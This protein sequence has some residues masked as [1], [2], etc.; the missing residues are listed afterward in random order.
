ME[1]GIDQTLMIDAAIIAMR[2]QMATDPNLAL[3]EEMSPGLI[4]ELAQS[5]RPAF[6]DHQMRTREIYIPRMAALFAKHLTPAEARA[7]AQFYR[8]DIGRRLLKLTSSNYS[9]D[10]MLAE[11]ME[12]NEITQEMVEKDVG[13]T[14]SNVVD[15]LTPEEMRELARASMD[16]PA[17]MK[18]NL[19]QSEIKAMRV[20]MENEPLDEQTEREMQAAM[21]AIFAR[22]FP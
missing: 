15:Q 2:R 11:A 16:N 22:R 6:K 7:A 8:S 5:T 3:A 17:I 13:T 10:A 9:M 14:L 1:E 18:L 12:E 4:D 20:E 19:A 21:E